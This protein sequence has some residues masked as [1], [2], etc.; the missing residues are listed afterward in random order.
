MFVFKDESPKWQ[1]SSSEHRDPDLTVDQ[2]R[3]ASTLSCN[4]IPLMKT[5]PCRNWFN[6]TYTR[7]REIVYDKEKSQ[8]STALYQEVNNYMI[9]PLSEF[10]KAC[11][12]L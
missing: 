8:N 7:L 3:I 11:P 5:G 6:S 10:K 4:V 9:K 2:I 12:H 1:N